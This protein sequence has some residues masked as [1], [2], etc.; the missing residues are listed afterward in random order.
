M[1][2]AKKSSFKSKV[3]PSSKG[4]LNLLHMDLCGPMRVASINGK[5]YILVIG[6]YYSRYTWT[7]FYDPSMKH[8]EFSKDFPTMIQRNLRT[9]VITVP[10]DRRHRVFLTRPLHAY[11]KKKALNI[12]FH[13]IE[14]LNRTAFVK[15]QNRSL[16]EAS[17]RTMLSASK[18]SISFWAEASC[19]PMLYST[20]QSSY[21]LM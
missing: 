21:R 16:V 14:H 6:L 7:L 4:R 20:D 1:S 17:C 19:N 15:R 12:N 8:P 9:Q 11:F 2:K 5:K 18:P 13:S 10:T 3:V